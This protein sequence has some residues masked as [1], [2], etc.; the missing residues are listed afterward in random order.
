MILSH[1]IVRMIFRPTL[2]GQLKFQTPTIFAE[3]RTM[4]GTAEGE[5]GSEMQGA[6]NEEG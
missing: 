6:E 5:Q 1:R 3:C 2:V 4:Q